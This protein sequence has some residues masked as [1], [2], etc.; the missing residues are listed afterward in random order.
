MFHANKITLGIRITLLAGAVTTA[1]A[2]LGAYAA[3][4]EQQVERIQ[5]T[6]SRIKS[7]DMEGSSPVTTISIDD[8]AKTGQMTVA[9]LLRSSNLNTFGS[10][11]ER[12]GSSAQSQSS[13]NLR[14]VGSERTLVLLN[15]KRMPGSPTLGGTAVNLNAITTAGIDRIEILSDGASA[16][17][18]SDA[19]AGVINII[20]KKGYEGLQLSATKTD[21]EQPGG[22]EW[23]AHVIGGVSSDKGNITFSLEHQ[24]REIIYQHDRWFSSSSNTDAAKYADTTG[25]STY[26]RNFND[27]TTYVTSPLAGC[28]N[29]DMVGDGHIYDA[30]DGDHVCGYDY[31]AKGADHAARTFDAGYLNAEYQISDEVRFEGQGIF[32]RNKTFGRYA[33]APGK[34]AVGAGVVDVKNYGPDGKYVD[35]TKNKNAG[36]VL[37]RFTG[38]GTRDSETIDHSTDIQL[39]FVGE[40]DALGWDFTYHYNLAENSNNGTG[41]VHRPTVE[42]LAAA[43]K[44]NFGPEGNSK[45]VIDSITHDIFQKDTMEFQSVNAGVNFDAIDLM[46]SGDMSWYFGTEFMDYKYTSAV[47]SESANGE[48]IGSAG[49]GSSGERDVY[50][51][52]GETTLPITDDLSMNAALR[53]DKYSDF[54]NAVTPKVSLRYKATDDLVLRASWGQGFRA[55]SLADLHAADSFSADTATDYQYCAQVGTAVAQCKAKQYDV[56]RTANADL[57][58]ETSDFYNLGAIYDFTENFSAKVEYYDLKID[59]VITLVSLDSLLSEETKVGYGNLKLGNIKRYGDTASGKISEATAPLVNGNSLSTSGLDFNLSYRDLETSIGDFSVNLDTTYVLDY[60]EEEYFDGPVHNKIGRN[61][62]PKIRSTG[63]VDWMMGDHS[64]AVVMHY[65]DG[66]TERTDPETFGQVGLLS[67]QTT[68]DAS[69][70]YNTSW[71]GKVSLGIRNLTNEDPVLDSSLDY[72]KGLYN[73]YGRTYNLSYTQTF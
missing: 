12:S 57:E 53:Y 68:F 42:A 41:Y 6:G 47:D 64:A 50:A 33:P 7:T 54:G 69:Y 27:G 30:G 37:Y 36:T 52:F 38:V 49:N 1:V 10:F 17:Y 11:S 28:D 46:G 24:Q 2:S 4:G 59:N 13:V 61:G 18:G 48:I 39:G 26:A 60:S 58:A 19:I 8:I 25:V 5:V 62:L 14:G 9:D 51:F 29:P 70:G 34:F 32:S 44:F 55:P 23:K 43:G 72:D 66:Q 20:T 16:V 71:N 67:S 63:T 65:I 15:G 56:T 45:E 31:T 40:H 73:L 21:P 35:T 22:E 3:D